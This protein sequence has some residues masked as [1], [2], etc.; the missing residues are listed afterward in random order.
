MLRSKRLLRALVVASALTGMAGIP[1]TLADDE[2][3]YGRQLMTRT[4]QQAYRQQMQTATSA[5]E[6]QR[7]RAE[8]H[9]RMQER[10]QARGVTL[11]DMPPAQAMGGR[12]PGGGAGPGGGR[13]P[14]PGGG[15]G[16]GMNGGGR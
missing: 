13:G 7:I 6:R 9:R 8:H 12:G 2:P 4:E 3:I 16:G 11:P 10:A 15:M 14:G 5:E 1:A